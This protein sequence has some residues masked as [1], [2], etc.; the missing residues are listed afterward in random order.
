MSSPEAYRSITVRFM[1]FR[2]LLAS[3]QYSRRHGLG[4][5]PGTYDQHVEGGSQWQFNLVARWP[6]SARVWWKTVDFTDALGDGGRYA[7]PITRWER[8]VDDE[9]E[10]PL[11]ALEPD[12]DP[13]NEIL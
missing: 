13:E 9:V 1:N 4:L 7:G 3:G 2:S 11:D 5:A 12:S 6:S 8:A 10:A